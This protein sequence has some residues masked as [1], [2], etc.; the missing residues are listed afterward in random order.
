MPFQHNPGLQGVDVCGCGIDV[1]DEDNLLAIY[2]HLCGGLK[3]PVHPV[4]VQ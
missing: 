3:A 1:N 4:P 2:D